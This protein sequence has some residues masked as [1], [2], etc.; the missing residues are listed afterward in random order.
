MFRTCASLALAAVL[1]VS[2]SAP[3]APDAKAKGPAVDV[4]IC[5]DCSGSM[6]GL[7]DSAKAKLWDIV[8]DLGKAKP[9]PNLRVALYSYGHSGGADKGYV[10]KDIDL[11]HDLDAVYQKL[12]AL[13][14]TGSVE[15]VGRVC[16]DALTEQK[17]S[18]EKKALKMIFVCGNESAEQDRKIGLEE[19]AKLA[20]G[21]DVIVNSI[22]CRR[23]GLP[24]SEAEGWRKLAKLAEGSFTQI[25]MDK[26]A[27]LAIKT[28]HD[29]KL[30][31]LSARLNTTYVAYGKE[32]VRKLRAEN[33]A[34]QDSNAA[35]APGAGAARAATKGGDL[36]R[37]SEWDI[38]DRLRD[39]PKFDL[40]KLKE[41]EL[42]EE[43]KKLKPQERKAYVEKKQEERKAIQ[44][45]IAELATKRA[46]YIKAEAK[47]QQK[48]GDKAFDEAVK[49]TVR[50]QAGRKGIKIPE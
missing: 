39:D 20:V 24:E 17:W 19:V 16:H 25:D 32:S 30:E 15:L 12:N 47:K 10:R 27:T 3:A 49:A 38:I 28:P 4:V 36:Y 41:E 14:I 13:Q 8:N 21:K 22:H 18:D 23:P 1:G 46:E 48:D 33:Q 44:K 34:K 45:E 35:K 31:E 5:I 6:Q 9:A 37:N 43:M 11:T 2:A 7:I 26:A 50:E 29:K 40:S 42:S